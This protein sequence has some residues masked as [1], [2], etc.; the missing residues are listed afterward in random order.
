MNG[1][2]I[3]SYFDD[4]DGVDFVCACGGRAVLVV[5]DVTGDAVLA[6]L[7]TEPVEREVALSA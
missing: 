4:A 1:R 7:A 3:C 5:D 2:H 6:S